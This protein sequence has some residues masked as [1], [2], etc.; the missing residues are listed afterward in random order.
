M[1]IA[2]GA[3]SESSVSDATSPRTWTH[4]PGVGVIPDWVL[5]FVMQNANSTDHIGAVT[6][7]GV[8]LTAVS[9]AFA[10]DTLG[11]PGTCKAYFKAGG[12]WGSGNRIV[13]VSND[14]TSVTFHGVAVS[15]S[16][17]GAEVYLAGIVLLQESQAL[18]EQNVTDASPG[19][20]SV[21]Y[22]G[23]F[24]G[25]VTAPG[26]GANST[27]LQDTSFGSTSASAV[28][29]TTAGQGSRPVGFSAVSD[30]VAAI[31]LVIREAPAAAA[32]PFFIPVIVG[33]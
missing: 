18:A 5:V 31:H 3:S 26:V 23:T 21:R 30:D 19:T 25:G 13:S 17:T 8:A 27:A 28:R 32:G 4:A 14:G 2:H 1:A 9:G 33:L 12:A 29:E 15:G 22:A 10:A 16:G 11:E 20:N 6:Y 7:D 24:Y